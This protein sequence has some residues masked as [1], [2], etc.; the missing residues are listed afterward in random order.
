MKYKIR[1]RQARRKLEATDEDL[2]RL[3]DVLHEVDRQV[4]ALKRQVGAA[5]RFQE[6]RDRLRGL[7]VALAATEVDA[8][9]HEEERLAASLT[10]SITERDGAAGRIA[11]LDADIETRRLKAAEADAALSAAQRSVDALAET[12]RKV[13][14]DNLV[15]RERR[16]S[17][18]DLGRR[19]SEEAR[20][21][22]E[23]VASAIARRSDLERELAAA[24]E[25]RTRSRGPRWRAGRSRAGGIGI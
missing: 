23:R 18:L 12:A 19:M 6:M 7:D 25:S 5:Q 24:R 13:E 1:E 15:R 3:Q 11:A 14:S 17:L 4:R 8:L 21:L 20:V 10:E 16:E 22:G 9:N 2:K